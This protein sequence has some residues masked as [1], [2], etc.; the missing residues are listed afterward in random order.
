MREGASQSEGESVR[1]IESGG[2]DVGTF[3]VS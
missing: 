1:E 2:N 3:K